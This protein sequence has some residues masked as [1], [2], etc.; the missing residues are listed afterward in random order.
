MILIPQYYWSKFTF[1]QLKVNLYKCS[2]LIVVRID[3]DDV[4]DYNYDNVRIRVVSLGFRYIL[5]GD[6]GFRS[7]AVSL[8]LD[9]TFSKAI[10]L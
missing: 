10:G 5:H 7:V 4:R 9:C 2:W 3:E 8:R 6:S 1:N